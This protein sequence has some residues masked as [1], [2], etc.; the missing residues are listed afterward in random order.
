MFS[1]YVCGSEL[2][3]DAKSCPVCGTSVESSP[4]PAL[5]QPA[6]APVSMA[7]PSGPRICP[8]RYLA[9]AE[10]KMVI[11]MLLGSF[12]IESVTTPDGEDAQERLA[13][14]MSPVGLRMTLR[15]TA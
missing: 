7:A 11:A 14:T 15:A 13:L 3:D 1:C 5:P 6:V 10:M 8:G 2:A 9:L 4:A 12:S